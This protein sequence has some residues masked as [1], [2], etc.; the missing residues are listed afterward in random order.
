AVEKQKIEE[1]ARSLLDA[2]K[3]EGR[4]PRDLQQMRH[5]LKFSP[6]VLEI[7]GRMKE[8]RDLPLL[9]QVYTDLKALLDAEDETVTV[10][11]TTAVPLDAELRKKVRDKCAAD[12]DAPIF[13]VEHVEPSIIGGIILEA[14]GHRRDAS[15]KAQLVNIRK[16]LG[17]SFAGG[18]K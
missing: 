18:D 11:V 10:D 17:S 1:Y 15:I 4:A 5:A 9:E 16:T 2:A 12:F 8:E 14:R 13:L 6:E 7:L 3:G